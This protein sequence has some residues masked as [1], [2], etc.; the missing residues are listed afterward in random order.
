MSLPNTTVTIAEIAQNAGVGTATVDRVLNKRSGVNSETEQK[1]LQA[2]RELGTPSVARGRPRTKANFK[3]AYVLP[4]ESSQFLD[5]L[6]RHI[7]QTAGDFRHQHITE[8]TYRIECDDV[9]KFGVDLARI[10][11]C[12][13]IVLMAPDL[14][15]VKLAIN[16]HVR[17]GVHVATLFSDV[18]GSMRQVHV[19]ADNR[20]AGRTAG[21]LLARMAQ[22]QQRSNLL[23]LSPTTRMSSEI[24]R[25]IGFAQV[26]EERFPN[27]QVIRG[28]DIS[29]N[30]DEA[31]D[32][33]MNY[34]AGFDVNS[35]A[36]VYAVGGA[37]RAVSKALK[38]LSIA[39]QVPLVAHDLT[40]SNQAMLLDGSLAYV[41]H[42]DVHYCVLTAAK[43]LR[44]LCDNVRGA[45][46]VVQPR[47]EILTAENLH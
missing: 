45:P 10:N 27:L 37:V 34:F 22:S 2:I 19:G 21:L 15:A 8:V 46:S 12:D 25:R 3:F 23:L 5:Q 4:A 31:F 40:A 42:Q 20:A 29:G 14:P 32:Q 17:A 41:L 39:G 28:N 26:V 9:A 1:V 44:G 36:G 30:D 18:A 7:A 6:E 16:D 47:V 11:D 24:E 38:A 43:V 35:I 33:L 13:A